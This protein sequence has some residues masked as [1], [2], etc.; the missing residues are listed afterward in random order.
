MYKKVSNEEI[1]KRFKDIE[2]I[3]NLNN[4]DVKL[5]IREMQNK[6]I[7]D[8][9]FLVYFNVKKYK[10]FPNYKDLKQEGFIGLIK[11][12][13]KFNYRKF[14][15]FFIFAN[16]RILNGI[17]RSAKKYDIVYN[18][19]KIK[20]VYC[21][22]HNCCQEIVED[23]DLEDLMYRKEKVEKII[24]VLNSLPLKEK[25]IVKVVFGIDSEIY[26]LRQ[27][28]KCC[29]LTYERIRQIKNIVLKKL[30][31]NSVLVDLM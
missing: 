17:M 30:K 24:K 26:T 19:Y 9:N 18:P 14:P 12:V 29:N 7:E 23:F 4:D 15:N 13:R 25:N 2:N 6:I 16:R 27:A 8:L 20:T 31:S 3:K 11:A 22:I 10:K 5:K 21:D 28:E 1:M